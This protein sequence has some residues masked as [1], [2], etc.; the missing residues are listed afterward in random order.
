M[1][2]NFFHYN[3]TN[4]TRYIAANGFITYDVKSVSADADTIWFGTPNGLYRFFNENWTHY[5]TTDGLISDDINVVKARNDSIWIGTNGNGITFFEYN[6]KNWIS[7][8]AA[9]GLP[10]A[11]IRDISLDINNYPVAATES[12]IAYWVSNTWFGETYYTG[13]WTEVLNYDK[14]YNKWVGFGNIGNGVDKQITG[15]PQNFKITGGL[16]K[17]DINDIK[18]DQNGILYVAT[19]GGGLSVFDSN[20]WTTFDDQNDMPGN[21]VYDIAIENDGS[22]WT[23]TTNGVAKK[24]AAVWNYYTTSDAG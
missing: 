11:Y 10:S 4:W 7:Y 13:I 23:A 19:Q 2:Y 5:T 12:G 6:L 15:P 17:N 9:D 3:G 16:A 20:V 21:F 18:S 24:N 8:T 22:I 14:D 1:L